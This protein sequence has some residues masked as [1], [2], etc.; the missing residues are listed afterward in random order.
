[1]KKLLP[2]LFAFLLTACQV[3][4]PFLP[5][6]TFAQS[7]DILFQDDFSDPQ[8]GWLTAANEVG[9]AEYTSDGLFHIRVDAP[10]YNFWSTPGL[11]VTNVIM[12]VDSLKFAGPE[13]NRI[14]LVCR[15]QNPQNYYF[16]IISTD[17][18][19]GVGKVKDGISTLLAQTQMERNSAVQSGAAINRLRGECVGNTL[20][21]YVN[22]KPLAIVNDPDFTQGDVGLL[23][24]AFD[25][26][27]VDV[28]FDNFIVTKP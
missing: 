23:V 6:D 12:E 11:K 20:I 27:G 26:A 14:G 4:L 25:D 28:Y 9:L 16:F 21:F 24:G 2:L 1:M 19:Y 15:Y 13:I 22:Q 18:Y 5:D 3:D 7:G 8:S 17:G 10:G